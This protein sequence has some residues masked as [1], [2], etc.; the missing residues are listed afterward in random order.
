MTTPHGFVSDSRLETVGQV[1]LGVPPEFPS[2]GGSC[3]P[4][5]LYAG[6]FGG[7]CATFKHAFQGIRGI[8]GTGVTGAVFMGLYLLMGSLVA[9]I[10]LHATVDLA[11][12][13]MAYRALQ[14]TETAA[15][16][17]PDWRRGDDRADVL[18]AEERSR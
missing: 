16:S 11:N 8:V 5:R 10:V 13:A 18:G 3:L 6:I 1:Y 2:T 17:S 4:T 15:S 9:P 7:G 14:H 12:G